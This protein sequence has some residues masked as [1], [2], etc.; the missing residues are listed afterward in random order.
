[1]RGDVSK[2]KELGKLGRVGYRRFPPADIV[3]INEDEEAARRGS[4]GESQS[5]ILSFGSAACSEFL[6]YIRL[7]RPERH[8]RDLPRLGISSCQSSAAEPHANGEH[9][10]TTGGSTKRTLLQ[11]DCSYGEP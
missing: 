11:G 10:K 4:E 3:S 9:G 8:W 1:M 7:P 6:S 5:W 2:T